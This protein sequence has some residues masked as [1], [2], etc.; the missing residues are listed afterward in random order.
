MV[1]LSKSSTIYVGQPK[2]SHCCVDINSWCNAVQYVVDFFL[3]QRNTKEMLEN[4]SKLTL[5][6]YNFKEGALARAFNGTQPEW[7]EREVTDWSRS[8]KRKEVGL[9]AQEV[10]SILP[11]AVHTVECLPHQFSC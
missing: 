5:Y 2:L 9:L 10:E 3:L 1:T 11:D 4:I 8:G 6:S 7:R